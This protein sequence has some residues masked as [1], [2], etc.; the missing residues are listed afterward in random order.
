MQV[1]KNTLIEKAIERTDKNFGALVDTLKGNTALL[2][3][4]DSILPS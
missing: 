1:A 2:F 3:S 4:Q